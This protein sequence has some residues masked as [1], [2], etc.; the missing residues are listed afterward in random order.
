[1]SI[2]WLLPCGGPRII[3][4][5]SGD[6]AGATGVAPPPA[7]AAAEATAA[8]AWRG[9]RAWRAVVAPVAIGGGACTPV[10]GGKDRGS[11][12]ERGPAAATDRSEC[13]DGSAL[14][15]PAEGG[16]ALPP[17]PPLSRGG[18][19]V[20]GPCT[21]SDAAPTESSGGVADSRDPP[22][23]STG[24]ACCC[25][26]WCCCSRGRAAAAATLCAYAAAWSA[27][28]RASAASRAADLKGRRPV[29]SAKSMTPRHQQSMAVPD[30]GDPLTIWR[31]EGRRRGRAVAS[32]PE[33]P[34][35]QPLPPPLRATATGAAA[36]LWR[37]VE[38]ASAGGLGQLAR[39]RV[40]GEAEV[41]DAAGAVCRQEH[42]RRRWE[43][44][45]VKRD[46]S[47]PLSRPSRRAH[48]LQLEVSVDDFSRM[49]SGDAPQHLQG[50]GTE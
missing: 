12:D 38:E 45:Q 13:A 50:E 41:R 6:E 36:H 33:A 29:S 11:S 17:L 7:V 21:C 40:G 44:R 9:L 39:P 32:E 24:L 47:P 10:P 30:D 4:P 2:A 20:R 28:S 3:P 31:R 27:R 48:I 18:S 35:Q 42:L 49:R 26:G 15:P 46:G 8:A 19:C 14:S 25:C 16:R 5:K 23:P 22:L 1:M 34:Q 43:W 37:Q